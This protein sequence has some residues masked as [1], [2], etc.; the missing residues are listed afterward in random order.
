MG[1][2]VHVKCLKEGDIVFYKTKISRSEY[3]VNS[4]KENKTEKYN[5]LGEPID[6]KNFHLYLKS[7]IIGTNKDD[8]DYWDIELFNDLGYEKVHKNSNLLVFYDN[9]MIEFK[10][11]S[12]VLVKNGG[13]DIEHYDERVVRWEATVLNVYEKTLEILFT[14]NSIEADLNKFSLGRPRINEKLIVKKS[15]VLF[16]QPS[17]SC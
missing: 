6:P 9:D 11:G 13:I 17:V 12:K 8:K 7:K 2:P 1:E 16:L 4:D 3:I 14:I 10:K 15:N 5:Y